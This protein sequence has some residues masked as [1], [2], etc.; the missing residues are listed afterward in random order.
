MKDPEKRSVER[1]KMLFELGEFERQMGS[2]EAIVVDEPGGRG[3][4]VRFTQGRYT[5]PIMVTT[6]PM[7]VRWETLG[8]NGDLGKFT[9]DL[10]SANYSMT[11]TRGV[12]SFELEDELKNQQI[13]D[14]QTR[15]QQLL[16]EMVDK[17]MDAMWSSDGLAKRKK[18]DVL[19]DAQQVLSLIRKV[20]L[21]D[22]PKDDP[23]VVET[24][25]A[26]FAKGANRPWKQEDDTWDLKLKHRVLDKG[27][28]VTIPVYDSNYEWLNEDAD[29]FA[30]VGRGDVCVV[31]LMLD[32][33][34]TSSGIYGVSAKVKDIQILQQ[35]RAQTSKRE[36]EFPT[37]AFKEPFKRAKT[38]V[39]A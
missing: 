24:A 4:R 26:A 21:K 7:E 17:A 5:G 35:R 22:V 39:A 15:F 27:E 28:P 32:P 14:Q 3:S 19:A 1:T 20:D 10:A 38:E 9:Q 18:A 30:G 6:P 33:Y 8:K 29:G 11:L 23:E 2:T 34:C 13:L 37:Y 25:K 16:K 31:R 36:L 12:S